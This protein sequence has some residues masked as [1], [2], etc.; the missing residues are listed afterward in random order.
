M[1]AEDAELCNPRNSKISTTFDE[2]EMF[3]VEAALTHYELARDPQAPG[4]IDEDIGRIRRKLYRGMSGESL[5]AP[6]AESQTSALPRFT[7]YT[8]FHLIECFVLREALTEYEAHC[9]KGLPQDT[10]AN[11]T[12]ANGTD[13]NGTD[14]TFS[15]QD[16]DSVRRK[17]PRFVSCQIPNGYGGEK[18]I[19]V[20]VLDD[21]PRR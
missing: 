3:I 21:P 6:D 2:R 14:A 7:F 12:D 20:A 9:R 10:D 8:I 11:G 5:P 16:V 15:A 19:Y 4:G 17:V 18:D 1:H 13:A